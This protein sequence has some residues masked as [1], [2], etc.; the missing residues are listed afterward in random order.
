MGGDGK[1]FSLPADDTDQTPLTP[2]ERKARAYGAP[3]QNRTAEA[4]AKLVASFRRHYTH[5]DP[6]VH[7]ENTRILREFE[8]ERDAAG[9]KVERTMRGFVAGLDRE[10][11]RAFAEIIVNQDIA[12]QIEDGEFIGV[13]RQG[14]TAEQVLVEVKADLEKAQKAGGE[15]VAQALAKRQ[16]FVRKFAREMV[17]AGLLDEKVL[18]DDRYFHRQVIAH[19]GGT[20]SGLYG[21]DQVREK[22]RGFQRERAG[23]GVDQIPFYGADQGR[24]FNTNYA[25]AEYEYLKQGL[26]ELA[27][28]RALGRLRA[29]NDRL[30]EVKA[31]AKARNR[32]AMDAW[33]ASSTKEALGETTEAEMEE[34]MAKGWDYE[35]RSRIAMRNEALAKLAADTDGRWG[36]PFDHVWEALAFRYQEW[37]QK[38]MDREPADRS[39]FQFDHPEWWAALG[40][41]VS[42]RIEVPATRADSRGRAVEYVGRPSEEAAGIF[43]AVSDREAFTRKTLTEEKEQ[44]RGPGYLTWQDIAGEL[45]GHREWQPEKGLQMGQGYVVKD[46]VVRAALMAQGIDP[47]EFSEEAP[48]VLPIGEGEA[49]RGMVVFG[50]KP[51]WLIPEEL[52]QQLDALEKREEPQAVRDTLEKATRAWKQW[53]LLNPLKVV[54]YNINNMVGDLDVAMT[55]PAI[56]R[57]VGRDRAQLVRDLWAWTHGKPVDA[58]TAALMEQAE[59]MGLI[60]SGTQV[61]EL[62]D[63]DRIPGLEEL[64]GK[65]AEGAWEK[66]KKLPGKWWSGARAFGRWREGILRLAAAR[67]FYRQISPV[68]RRYLASRRDEM[69]QLYDRWAALEGQRQRMQEGIS[70]RVYAENPASDREQATLDQLDAEVRDLK[71]GIAAKLAREFLGDYGSLSEAGEWLRRSLIPFWSW[72]E[73]NA[74]RY[75]R[76]IKNARHE[77]GAGTGRAIGA[78]LALTAG[79]GLRAGI[80]TGAVFAW[81]EMMKAMLDIKDEDDPN[82]D[83][84]LG[85]LRIILWKN[86]DGTPGG[87]RVAGALADAL[88]WLDL[89]DAKQKV[90]EVRDGMRE[91]KAGKALL[92]VAADMAMAPVNRLVNSVNPMLKEAAAQASGRDWWPDVRSP[93]PIG[94]R[95]E[96]LAGMFGGPVREALRAAK[97]KAGAGRPIMGALGLESWDPKRAATY[98]TRD[99]IEA[100]ASR[101][102]VA[103][104]SGGGEPTERSTA[105]REARSALANGERDRAKR[106]MGRYYDS[107]GKPSSLEQ[108]RRN[109][110][111]LAALKLVDRPRFKSDLD[112]EGKSDLDRAIKEHETMWTGI[113]GFAKLAQE[114]WRERRARGVTEV[115]P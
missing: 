4:L 108:S 75:V 59:K 104:R 29:L 71:A 68:Q 35:W 54:Q 73:I 60:D 47:D 102:G 27:K 72:M 17:E 1:A 3:K 40:W 48:D 99:R 53:I 51:V 49:R 91:G 96:H 57:E 105:L 103:I 46:Q 61:A 62:A 52:A 89:D 98:R 63:V 64:F 19:L 15:N 100:W 76:I 42:R 113:E 25:Q 14:R 5:L 67:R 80:L 50:R 93:R 106:W 12:R 55:D 11:A 10:Q 6:A 22:R 16:A 38:N 95:L 9:A 78:S 87:I 112:A 86:Q 8:A 88:G 39:A 33:F 83:Q 23:G 13:D 69:D 30:P 56:L 58:D 81:N 74:P 21:S 82:K 65:D 41:L 36:T 44:G 24:D 7:A 32:A 77:G 90:Q 94:D 114:A 18:A 37:Y 43:K 109:L 97:D 31:E 85:K 2:A 26:E 84:G 111:P 115:S 70:R 79:L 45:D 66:A 107:G 92:D 110:H 28:V 34:E 101:N 20:A